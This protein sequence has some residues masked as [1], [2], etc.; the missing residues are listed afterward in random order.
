VPDGPT[1]QSLLTA[2]VSDAAPVIDESTADLTLLG[3]TR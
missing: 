2:Q 1:H 3:A